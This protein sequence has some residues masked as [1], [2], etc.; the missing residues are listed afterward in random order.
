MTSVIEAHERAVQDLCREFGVERLELFGSACTPAFDA[1]RSDV[2]FLVT[3]PD[4]YDFGRWMSRFT[5]LRE[6][7]SAVLGRPVDL[8]MPTA[9]DN[10]YFRQEAEKTRTVIYDGSEVSQVA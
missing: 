1:Q 4:D 8:V 10:A 2:D 7:L 3:F 5:E 9:L 6:R